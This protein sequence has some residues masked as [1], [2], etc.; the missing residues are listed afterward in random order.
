M[1]RAIGLALFAM[2]YGTRHY[3]ACSRTNAVL[4]AVGF[5]SLLKLG[6]L[7]AAE[8]VALVLLG[9]LNPSVGSHAIGRLATNFAPANIGMD[10]FV[11][12]SCRWL[13]LSACRGNFTSA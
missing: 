2:I 9:C 1:V 10:F 8:A 12:S 13:R 11:I 5:E 3:D 7:I 6:A 4:F